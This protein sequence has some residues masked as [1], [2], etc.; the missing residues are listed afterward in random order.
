MNFPKNE[1]LTTPQNSNAKARQKE[2]LS[3]IKGLLENSGM[4]KSDSAFNSAR[5]AECWEIM[6]RLCLYV[7]NLAAVATLVDDQ[8]GEAICFSP[9]AL[10]EI[11]HLE[12]NMSEFKKSVA[13]I[14]ILA[15]KSASKY[16]K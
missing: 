15:E 2:L 12:S 9:E 6:N 4:S 16:R 7:E 3:K 10:A 14:G 5:V 8:N 13:A 1:F 11:T